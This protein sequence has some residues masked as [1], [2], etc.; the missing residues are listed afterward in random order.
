M[1]YTHGASGYTN[2]KC[3]CETCTIA[4]SAACA[5][6]KA[7]RAPL[8]PDDP[9]H[10]STNGYGNWGCRCDQCRAA[11]VTAA[12]RRADRVHDHSLEG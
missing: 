12:R 3:R 5:R 2:Y 10:G 4:H 6:M 7:A 11:K 8:A 1:A 9:R